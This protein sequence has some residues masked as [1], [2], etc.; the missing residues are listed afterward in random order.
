M[1]VSFA[2]KVASVAETVTF[3]LDDSERALLSAE[4]RRPIAVR[5]DAGYLSLPPTAVAAIEHLLR[6]LAGGARVLVVAEDAELTTQQAADLLGL[7]RT[8]VARL[9]DEG[10]LPAHMAGTHRRIRVVDAVAYARRRAAR[11]AGVDAVADANRSIGL[12]YS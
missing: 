7:S 8:F 10:K 9:V 3:E 5:T 4:L 2:G 12:E 1:F 6:E 11:L